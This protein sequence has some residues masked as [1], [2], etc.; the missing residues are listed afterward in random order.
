MVLGLATSHHK[1]QNWCRYVRVI[2]PDIPS[3]TIA[4][5]HTVGQGCRVPLLF[6]EWCKQILK[7]KPKIENRGFTSVQMVHTHTA[8]TVM[9]NKHTDLLVLILQL[10][11]QLLTIRAKR[12]QQPLSQP[13]LP[14]WMHLWS[15]SERACFSGPY[16]PMSVEKLSP[17]IYVPTLTTWW[18]PLKQRTFQNRR[19]HTI[20]FKC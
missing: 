13:L 16:W 1:K 5:L 11:V 12:S 9:I 18:Q 8:L 19:K 3:K 20:L 4:S 7:V 14:T 10:V 15:V 17:Y 2:S 6:Q